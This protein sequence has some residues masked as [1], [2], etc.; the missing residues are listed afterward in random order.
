MRKKLQT[1]FSTRQYMLSQDF[2]IYY[3]EDLHFTGVAPHSHDYYEFY[4][5]LEGAISMHISGQ[6]HQLKSGDVLLIPPGI[7]HFATNHNPEI[8]YRRFVFWIQPDYVNQLH[9]LSPCY[10]YILQLASENQYYRFHYDAL[11]F[12]SIQAKIF[13]IIEENLSSHFG[14]EASVTLC[15]NDLLLYMNRT[16]YEM[17]H[18]ESLREE[19]NLYHNVMQYIEGHL[20][21]ELSLD[22]IAQAFYVSKYHV[23]HI[24]KEHMG[25]SLHQYITKKRLARCRDSILSGVSISKAFSLYGFSDYSSFFRAFKKEY[26]ISPKEY[27]E[28]H[29]PEYI[30]RQYDEHPADK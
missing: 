25:I 14:K 10:T 6:P 2:E 4:F 3:Y 11:S 24:F 26:G 13:R 28:Q 12:H 19:Q 15:I 1:E 8:P 16:V 17:K 27:R 7:S 23:A 21:E 22:Q 9:S 30:S 29:V 18:P 5:F 20:E